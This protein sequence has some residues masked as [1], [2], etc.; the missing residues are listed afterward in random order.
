M[1]IL[2]HNS[3]LRLRLKAVMLLL[4]TAGVLGQ[5]CTHD[6]TWWDDGQTVHHN[7]HYNPPTI[8]GILGYWHASNMSLYIPVTYTVWGALA[9]VAQ[10]QSADASGARLNPWI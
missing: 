2:K 8:A 1:A 6:F 9:Y 5:V 7:P 10:L 4:I 3:H